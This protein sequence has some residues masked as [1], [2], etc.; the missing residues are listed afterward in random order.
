MPDHREF[1]RP[2][3]VSRLSRLDIVARLVVEGFITGLHK[4]PYHGFSVEFAEYRPYMPGD[5]IRDV[6]WKAY[7]KTD[8]LYVKE[9]EEETNLKA[10]L[11]LDASGSMGY[12]SAGITKFRYG[13]LT[14]AALS[15][16]MLRQRDAVGLVLFDAGIRRYIPPRSVT[17]HLHT[18]LGEIEAAKA[19]ADT[20]LSRTFHDLAERIRRRGL[21]IVIS[22][23]TP[24]EDCD[25]LSKRRDHVGR[26]L[27]GLK[28]F[29]HRKHEVI[30][31]HLLDPK[32]LDLTFDRETRFVGLERGAEVATEPWHIAEDYRRVM[33]EEIARYRRECREGLI[34]YVPVN[35]AEPFDTVLFNYLA[36][37][38][39]L[40]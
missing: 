39:K 8:R 1:L 19:G 2:D 20:D 27:S 9:H 33:R 16:L 30:V 13:C 12:G 23:F 11:L 36:K 37:R 24:T 28:H 3:V 5:S 10:Y 29:R 4:S 35:T 17:T 7:A 34:D 31:F 25:S 21:I 18:L 15:H 22:D 26:V 38:K 40:G 32:E 6:D 14:A